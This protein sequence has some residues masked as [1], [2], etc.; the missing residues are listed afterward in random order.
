MGEHMKFAKFLIQFVFV[1]AL[2][3]T[4][5]FSQVTGGAVTGS[6]VDPNGAVLRGATVVLKDKARGQEFTAQ[7]TDAG[8]YQFPNVQT[9]DY[10]LTVT[11]SGFTPVT[12]DV[13]VSLNQ[14]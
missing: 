6:V 14:T 4:G 11:A 2:S 8:S 9:G 1:L 3:V 7:T 10:T 12:R 5:A 13:I